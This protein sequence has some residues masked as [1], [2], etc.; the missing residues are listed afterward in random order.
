MSGEP[1]RF[2]IELMARD[3][4]RVAELAV[5]LMSAQETR[6]AIVDLRHRLPVTLARGQSLRMTGAIDKLPLV[7]GDYRAG[8][9]AVAGDFTGNVYDL[10]DVR[11]VARVSADGHAPY[12]AAYRG[13]VELDATIEAPSPT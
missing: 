8:L 5:L 9:Y 1:V 6:V 2:T 12:P 13:V 10:A 11:V 7:E 3:T 4:A